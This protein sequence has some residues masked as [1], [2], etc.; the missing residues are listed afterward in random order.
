MLQLSQMK[1]IMMKSGLFM[2]LRHHA[3]MTML[4]IARSLTPAH[5][6][7]FYVEGINV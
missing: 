7:I 1:G 6:N 2:F 5:T 3:R 4:L